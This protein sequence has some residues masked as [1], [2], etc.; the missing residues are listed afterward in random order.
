MDLTQQ[1]SLGTSQTKTSPPPDM[2]NP[3]GDQG[4]PVSRFANIRISISAMKAQAEPQV[5]KSEKDPPP[6][7]PP[8]SSPSCPAPPPPPPPP[9]PMSTPPKAVELEKLA[10]GL[11]TEKSG[12]ISIAP[13]AKKQVSNY[14]HSVSKPTPSTT[15]AV[16]KAFHIKTTA[17]QRPAK[18]PKQT[19]EPQRSGNGPVDRSSKQKDILRDR[20]DGEVRKAAPISRMQKK[21]VDSA[22]PPPRPCPDAQAQQ[23]SNSALGVCAVADYSRGEVRAPEEQADAAGA[24]L[25]MV[26]RKRSQCSNVTLTDATPKQYTEYQGKDEEKRGGG[27]DSCEP[28]GMTGQES[29]DRFSDLYA[30]PTVRKPGPEECTKEREKISQVDVTLGW[31]GSAKARLYRGEKAQQE[32]DS[33]EESSSSSSRSS[34]VL[35]GGGDDDDDDDDDGVR[36][37]EA[38]EGEAKSVQPKCDSS[39]VRPVSEFSRTPHDLSSVRKEILAKIFSKSSM[40]ENH[41]NGQF[42]RRSSTKFGSWVSHTDIRD[43]DND[44]AADVNSSKQ[45]SNEPV[46]QISTDDQKR[47]RR[48]KRLNESAENWINQELLRQLYLQ[49]VRRERQCQVQEKR[50]D[51]E[52]KRL[53]RLVKQPYHAF[54]GNSNTGP[55]GPARHGFSGQQGVCSIGQQPCGQGLGQGLPGSSGAALHQ[56]AH[57][58]TQGLETDQPYRLQMPSVSQ[59]CDDSTRQSTKNQNRVLPLRPHSSASIPSKGHFMLTHSLHVPVSHPPSQLK[60]RLLRTRF[61][62]HH[63]ALSAKGIIPSPL[64]TMH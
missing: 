34:S 31:R 59:T 52:K 24:S 44:V 30:E 32:D 20:V 56:R 50:A 42:S 54:C 51:L 23:E 25:L 9:P 48:K 12:A 47:L 33:D 3:P 6:S 27:E 37:E 19:Q 41:E 43:L 2:D 45:A 57:T 26:K 55:D 35:R 39:L 8:P 63:R 53:Q 13:S 17:A 29:S 62:K 7:P 16:R 38:D 49:R 10:T 4:L 36:S 11:P 5:N 22:S 15:K 40:S 60:E 21:V 14:K 28:I 18:A 58:H 64:H 61:P 46:Q 1:T